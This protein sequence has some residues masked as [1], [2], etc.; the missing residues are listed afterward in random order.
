M[1][2]RVIIYEFKVQDLCSHTK[3]DKILSKNLDF[4]AFEQYNKG[5]MC[6]NRRMTCGFV[7]FRMQRCYNYCA[8]EKIRETER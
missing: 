7:A 8:L 4:A 6:Q 3:F 1:N 2:S 5:V